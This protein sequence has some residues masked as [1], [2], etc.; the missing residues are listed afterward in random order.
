MPVTYTRTGIPAGG[1]QGEALKY[2]KARAEAIHKAYGV[3]TEVRVRL[4]GPVGQVILI[5][6]LKS[7]Q[8]LADIKKRVIAD[9]LAGKIPTAPADVFVSGED[10]IWIE[11]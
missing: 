6:R 3:D 2:F 10:A 9:T 7:V 4:G 8:E 1:K 11:A 5:S